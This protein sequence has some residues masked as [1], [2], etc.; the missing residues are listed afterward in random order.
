MLPWEELFFICRGVGDK[1]TTMLY[2]A[3]VLCMEPGIPLS[4]SQSQNTE[5]LFNSSSPFVSRTGHEEIL[6]FIVSYSKIC[7]PYHGQGSVP[8]SGTRNTVKCQNEIN[9][10][11]WL[12]SLPRPLPQGPNT[13]LTDVSSLHENGY[14]SIGFWVLMLKLSPDIIF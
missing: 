10:R 5:M 8:V 13:L 1:N 4:Q 12:G 14:F 2:K 11:I 7:N 9:R 3:S 6:P